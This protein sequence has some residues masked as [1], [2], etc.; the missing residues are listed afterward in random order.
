[1]K[2]KDLV[3][4]Q[5]DATVIC[6]EPKITPHKEKMKEILTMET[7]CSFIN[8]KATTVERLGSIGGKEG[9]AQWLQCLCVVMVEINDKKNVFDTFLVS[10]NQLGK[11]P[12]G[13]YF[14]KNNLLQV[15]TEQVESREGVKDS[16]LPLMKKLQNRVLEAYK[17]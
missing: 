9:I 2:T 15:A 8:I 12:P 14:Q 1:M 3:V 7:N 6:E 17:E 5:I 11:V 4:Y 10:I 13:N 16:L